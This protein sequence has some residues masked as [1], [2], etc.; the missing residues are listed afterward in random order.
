MSHSYHIFAR[1]RPN[2]SAA[3]KII[4]SLR[5]LKTTPTI[6]NKILGNNGFLPGNPEN[7]FCREI[8]A[9]L[10]IKKNDLSPGGSAAKSDGTAT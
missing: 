9:F 10:E 8:S 4:D 5:F 3:F 7:L 1:S 6:N 2:S